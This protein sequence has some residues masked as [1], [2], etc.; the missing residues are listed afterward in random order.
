M[1]TDFILPAQYL[2]WNR[3]NTVM[4]PDFAQIENQ[5]MLPMQRM[6]RNKKKKRTK[7][8]KWSCHSVLFDYY[9]ETVN[10]CDHRVIIR[11]NKNNDCCL[12]CIVYQFVYVWSKSNRILFGQLKT[13][14]NWIKGYIMVNLNCMCYTVSQ[15]FFALCWFEM[16]THRENWRSKDATNSRK[17][18]AKMYE[19]I[20][21]K[22]K[23]RWTK[24]Q[25]EEREEG[26]GG[27]DSENNK[28]WT[29]CRMRRPMN[30][31]VCAPTKCIIVAQL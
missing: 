25:E 19:K 23:D 28:K 13:P 1:Q 8:L 11:I 16:N 7:A 14:H 5:K 12:M 26:G 15:T 29:K 18:E 6:R 17:Y 2:S 3:V 30:S 9:I 22:N 4:L 24:E 31:Y 27:G 20:K 10:E 21:N